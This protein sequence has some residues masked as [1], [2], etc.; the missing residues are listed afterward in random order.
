MVAVGLVPELTVEAAKT[1]ALGAGA[2]VV[3]VYGYELTAEEVAENNRIKAG[4]YPSGRLGP[5]AGTGR[6][7]S[8]TRANWQKAGWRRR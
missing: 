7:S 2:R 8:T 5:T 4:P 6:P 3:G 1:A